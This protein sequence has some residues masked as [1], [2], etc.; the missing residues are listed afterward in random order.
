MQLLTAAGL[1]LRVGRSVCLC[2]CVCVFIVAV[3]GKWARRE[4]RVTRLSLSCK[5]AAVQDMT[6]TALERPLRGVE[7]FQGNGLKNDNAA[8]ALLIAAL[9]P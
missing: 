1:G 3:S 6:A 4:T 5:N 9:S 8:C 7:H 2:V